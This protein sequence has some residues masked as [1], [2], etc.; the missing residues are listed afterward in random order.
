[1][2]FDEV[3]SV[4]AAAKHRVRGACATAHALVVETFFLF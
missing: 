3:N 2:L 4:D 1:M